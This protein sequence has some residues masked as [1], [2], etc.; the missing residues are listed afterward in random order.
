M[1]A[2]W[3]FSARYV[4]QVCGEG[5]QKSL[6][7]SGS[8]TNCHYRNTTT[9]TSNPT[10]MMRKG[11][12]GA[13]W[14]SPWWWTYH[15]SQVWPPTQFLFFAFYKGNHNHLPNQSHLFWSCLLFFPA[16][17]LSRSHPWGA[18][19]AAHRASFINA[20][21]LI[22]FYASQ[23]RACQLLLGLTA[24]IFDSLKLLFRKS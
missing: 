6:L 23:L 1:V 10:Y 19:W 12:R 21:K 5:R 17:R 20:A 3:P 14:R 22:C 2:M 18:F 4:T 7:T 11:L 24:A 9:S 8:R 13:C 16:T 15:G